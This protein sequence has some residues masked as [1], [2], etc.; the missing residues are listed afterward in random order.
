MEVDFKKL[1]QLNDTIMFSYSLI[2][3]GIRLGV[4][5]VDF[6]VTYR[7]TQALCMFSTRKG[8]LFT[9]EAL[10][11]YS[12]DSI[13]SLISSYFQVDTP[14]ASMV[15][16]PIM[17]QDKEIVF[18]ISSYKSIPMELI[19]HDDKIKLEHDEGRYFI[20]VNA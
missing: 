15:I 12:C 5:S 14:K 4:S 6:I 13:E 18:Q 10:A 20:R 1:L 3:S 11:K 16:S 17:V 19:K 7:T 2:P 9:T 8:N